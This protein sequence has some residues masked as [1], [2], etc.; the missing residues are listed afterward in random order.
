MLLR[1][2]V[3]DFPTVEQLRD[4][5]SHCVSDL[6][7]ELACQGVHASDLVWPIQDCPEIR[8]MRASWQNSRPYPSDEEIVLLMFLLA[9]RNREVNDLDTKGVDAVVSA[10]MI[11]AT[12]DP[13]PSQVHLDIGR[14]EFSLTA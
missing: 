1:E 8:T 2:P 4:W 9:P 14:R 10:L 12:P 5:M 11:M 7:E 6:R 3:P 13:T